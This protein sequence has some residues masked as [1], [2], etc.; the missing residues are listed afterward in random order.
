MLAV[1]LRAGLAL[2]VLQVAEE[3]P[4]REAQVPVPLD[5][6]DAPVN[7]LLAIPS[8][9]FG[10]GLTLALLADRSRRLFIG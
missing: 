8:V 1:L 2:L 3:L 6:L 4:L 7:P 9:G 5:D 10:L